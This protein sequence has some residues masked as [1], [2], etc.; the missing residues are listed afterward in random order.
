[1][2]EN[3][4]SVVRTDPGGIPSP[5]HVKWAGY[6]GAKGPVRISSS[7]PCHWRTSVACIKWAPRKEGT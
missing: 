6:S 2:E 3:G 5:D 1:M 4:T 7:C